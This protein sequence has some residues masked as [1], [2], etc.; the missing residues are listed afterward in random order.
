VYLLYDF[1]DEYIYIYIY[2][3]GGESDDTANCAWKCFRRASLEQRYNMDEQDAV[4]THSSCSQ[5]RTKP[6]DDNNCF[7]TR[8]Y[9]PQISWREHILYLIHSWFRQTL[10]IATCIF[11]QRSFNFS[12]RTWVA[13]EDFQQWFSLICPWLHVRLSKE[14]S[15][16]T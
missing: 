3:A 10:S 6:D 1:Y 12:L 16:T 15:A 2:R 8:S 5:T 14:T 9:S 13:C 7:P 11:L 4:T